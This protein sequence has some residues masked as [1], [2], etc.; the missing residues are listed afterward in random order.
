M[1]KRNT[2]QIGNWVLYAVIYS[3]K[4]IFIRN[5]ARTSFCAFADPGLAVDDSLS[6][7]VCINFQFLEK[8]AERQNFVKRW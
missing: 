2:M 6:S 3:K 1:Y 8:P 5:G 7:F 4:T